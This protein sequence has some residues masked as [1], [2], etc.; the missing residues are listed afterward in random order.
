MFNILVISSSGVFVGSGF[1]P[2]L[3]SVGYKTPPYVVKKDT[4]SFMITY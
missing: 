3:F 1:I 2:D 4:L